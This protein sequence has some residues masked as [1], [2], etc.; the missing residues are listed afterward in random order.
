MVRQGGQRWRWC[1]CPTARCV[2]YSEFV[3]SA[4]NPGKVHHTPDKAGVYKEKQHES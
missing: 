1:R 2:R 3:Q 4:R